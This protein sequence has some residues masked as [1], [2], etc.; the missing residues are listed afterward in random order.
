VSWSPPTAGGA[1]IGYWLSVSGSYFGVFPTEA[2]VLT[3]T[4]AP[5]S[6]TVDVMAWNWC[7]SVTT[8]SQTV[9]VP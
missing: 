2:R 3:G 5:G 6:Y 8:L 7:G 4:V 1:V 9:I